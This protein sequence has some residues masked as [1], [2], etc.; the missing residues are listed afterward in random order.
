MEL[1]QKRITSL[2]VKQELMI[3]ELYCF[4]SQKFNGYNLFWKDLANEKTQHAKLIKKLYLESET[5][6]P[7]FDEEKIKVETLESSLKNIAKIHQ[8]AKARDFHMLGA[9]AYSFIYECSLIEKKIYSRLNGLTEKAIHL[10]KFLSQETKHHLLLI[11]QMRQEVNA[12]RQEPKPE[13]TR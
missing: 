9:L 2:L 8:K 7:L 5:N 3:S 1:N 6:S 11:Q 10:E 4:F 12:D 13:A